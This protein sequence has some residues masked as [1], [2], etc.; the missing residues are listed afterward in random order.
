M[1]T[2]DFVRLAYIYG[3]GRRPDAFFPV[4][5]APPE[6]PLTKHSERRNWKALRNPRILG[7]I[8]RFLG[9]ASRAVKLH[10]HP[11]KTKSDT[12]KMPIS[13]LP[14]ANLKVMETEK[15]SGNRNSKE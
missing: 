8:R 11:S 10:S 4:A 3:D 12:Y 1:S 5:L 6:K 14:F 9:L 15:S 13:F 2:Q 7:R